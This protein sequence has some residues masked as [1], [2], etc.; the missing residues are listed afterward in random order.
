[1]VDLHP[2]ENIYS[3]VNSFTINLYQEMY[4]IMFHTV[5]ILTVT[6]HD[7]TNMAREIIQ[8][9]LPHR[10]MSAMTVW[11]EQLKV[12]QSMQGLLEKQFNLS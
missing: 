9:L 2:I 7:K 6:A 8:G 11:L 12:L 1:M 3:P 5:L 10:L 4:N